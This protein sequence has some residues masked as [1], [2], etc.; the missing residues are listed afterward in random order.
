M[1]V[2]AFPCGFTSF[3]AFPCGSTPI[4]RETV[5]RSLAGVFRVHQFEKVEQFVLTSPEDG[6][7]WEMFKQMSGLSEEFYQSLGLP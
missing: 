7:S 1:R 3:I 6:K 5:L 4:H 2:S